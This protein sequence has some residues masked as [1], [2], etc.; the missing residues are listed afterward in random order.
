MCATRNAQ[1]H[2]C[3]PD[4]HKR[5]V[6]RQHKGKCSLEEMQ[7]VYDSVCNS[8]S[9]CKAEAVDEF[10]PQKKRRRPAR[11]RSSYGLTQPSLSSSSSA[12]GPATGSPSSQRAPARR[13]AAWT[14]GRGPPRRP[15]VGPRAL[16]G[17]GAPLPLTSTAGFSAVRRG[18]APCTDACQHSS[19]LGAA[20]MPDRRGG[21][22][23]RAPLPLT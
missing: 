13:G 6:H 9:E 12:L 5:G 22:A 23:R 7:R 15:L 10:P 2:A 11:L 18:S 4:K 3:R 20:R 1:P 8:T 17:S 19:L 21:T 16:R 14:G